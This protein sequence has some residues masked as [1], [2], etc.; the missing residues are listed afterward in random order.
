[1]P[2]AQIDEDLREMHGKV[3]SSDHHVSFKTHRDLNQSLVAV[4][5]SNIAVI[6]FNLK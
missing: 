6:T 1:M 3:Y 5:V 4:R 2:N